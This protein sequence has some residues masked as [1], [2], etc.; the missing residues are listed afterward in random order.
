[1]KSGKAYQLMTRIQQRQASRGSQKWLQALI[2]EHSDVVNRQLAVPLGLS[3]TD[4]IHW[5]SPLE[6]DDYAEY[7]DQAFLDRLGISLDSYPFANFWPKRGPVWDGLARTESG[8]VLLVEAKAHI[9]EM[10]SPASAASEPSLD[11]IRRS[12]EETKRFLGSGSTVDWSTC[13]YQYTNRLAHLYLL[14]ELNGIPAFLVFVYFIGDTDMG[15]PGT[16][17]EWEGGIKLMESFLGLRRHR[18]SRYVVHMFIDACAS[19]P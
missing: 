18:L 16:K 17:E 3:E 6:N 1:V 12:L 2:N 15:G 11:V 5:L 13:F 7:S 10:V 4:S 14:R 8:Q 9:P 19:T